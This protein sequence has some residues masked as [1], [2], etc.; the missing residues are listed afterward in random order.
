MDAR[1][2]ALIALGRALEETGYSFVTVCPETHRRV[3]ARAVAAGRAE[4]RT[5]RDAFG[6]SRAFEASALPAT[7]VDLARAAGV[8]VEEGSRLRST[9]RFSTLRGR[10]FVHS[11]Y[12]TL[13]PDA[14]FFGP[15]TYR[16]ADL[17]AGH[18]PS[19]KRVVDV[20]CGSGAGGI[21]ASPRAERVVLADVNGAAL[22]FAAVNSALARCED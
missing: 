1:S 17:I 6:W 12:P 11:A 14:V 5:L 10:L 8:L 3:D 18:A 16:F 9:V 2:K 19:A 15:D 21:V 7:V 13:A 20:G 22:A 4:A